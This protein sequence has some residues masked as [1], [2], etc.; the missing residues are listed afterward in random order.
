MNLIT[1]TELRTK[2]NDLVEFLLSGE[3]VQIV[4]R[5]KLIGTVKPKKVKA[6]RFDPEKAMKIATKLRYPILS[7]TEI[8][9]RYRAA[10]MKKHGKHLPRH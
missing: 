10:M 3:E 4:H 7:D 6:E 5:S 1:T 9:K 2:T 8:D